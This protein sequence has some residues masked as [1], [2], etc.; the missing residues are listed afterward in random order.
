MAKPP[1][2]ASPEARWPVAMALVGVGG[3]LFAL[4][5]S[6][7]VGPRWLLLAIVV[8]LLVPAI[9]AHR[10][11]KHHLDRAIGYLIS[12]IITLALVGSLVLLITTLPSKAETPASLLRSAA[13]L[14]VTNIFVFAIWYWRLD[15][16]GPHRRERRAKHTDGAF[17]FPQMMDSAPIAHP[18]SWS[19]RFVD[20]VF[21]AFNTSTAFSP[22]DTAVLSRWAKG[23]C[24]LQAMI[25]LLIVAILASRAVG[26]L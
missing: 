13:V 6:L 10:A 1:D 22:T 26:L 25:S 17:F 18:E 24:M 2:L 23:L 12:G 15:A 21:L 7:V 11:G 20:Y 3:I 4:P 9:L 16:G 19:P 5:D 8:A 14:W